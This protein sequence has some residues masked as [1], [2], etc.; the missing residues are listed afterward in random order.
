MDH[1]HDTVSSTSRQST[2]VYARVCLKNFDLNCLFVYISLFV[3]EKMHFTQK[4][5][6]RQTKGSSLSAF[7]RVIIYIYVN[8]ILLFVTTRLVGCVTLTLTVF[9]VLYDLSTV[10]KV[11]IKREVPH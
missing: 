10:A 1:V 8:I 2:H 5:K 11:V 3:T 6:S 9:A 4:Y 7:L